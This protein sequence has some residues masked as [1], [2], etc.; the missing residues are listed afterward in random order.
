MQNLADVSAHMSQN[1]EDVEA[2]V[3]DP[4]IGSKFCSVENEKYS[5]PLSDRHWHCAKILC[6]KYKNLM[7]IKKYL[8]YWELDVLDVR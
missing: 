6:R 5:L 8:D 2:G 4:L 1:S 3:A 7:W